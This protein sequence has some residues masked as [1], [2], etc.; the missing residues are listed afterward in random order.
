MVETRTYLVDYY[1]TF[2]GEESGRLTRILETD[3]PTSAWEIVQ[4]EVDAQ[5]TIHLIDVRRVE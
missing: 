3:S 2:L 4:E 1:R 5:T